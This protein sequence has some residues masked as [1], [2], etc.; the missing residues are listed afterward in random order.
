M[1]LGIWNLILGVITTLITALAAVLWHKLKDLEQKSEKTEESLSKFK[2]YVSE[3][4]THKTDNQDM[5]K[6][7]NERLDRMEKE[8][9]ENIAN[10][11]K[12]LDEGFNMLYQQLL[13]K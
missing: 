1:E 10:L 7:I 9:R 6:R 2:I 8:Q 5:E 12:R 3:N 4:Y 13:K 11:G